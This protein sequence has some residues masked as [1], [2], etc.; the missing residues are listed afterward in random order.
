MNFN[1]ESTRSGLTASDI[2]DIRTLHDVH[3]KND[4]MLGRLFGVSRK[5]IYNIVGRKTWKEVPDPVSIKGFKN[6]VLYPDGRVFSQTSM[7]FLNG[8]DRVAGMAYKLMTNKG[9]RKTVV[10]SSLLK[11]YFKK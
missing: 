6:Y 3:G 10:V 7:K 8:M 5:T 9:E 2:L 4:A 11:K 1:K